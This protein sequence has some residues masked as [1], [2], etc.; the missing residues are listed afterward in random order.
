M[1]RNKCISVYICIFVKSKAFLICQESLFTNVTFL[2]LLER[3][4]MQFI[5]WS[6]NQVNEFTDN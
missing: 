6:I 2:S 4:E 5:D 1:I 3:Q